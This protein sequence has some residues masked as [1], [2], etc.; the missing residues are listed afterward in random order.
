VI[1]VS[2][3]KVQWNLIRFV[4]L[5]RNRKEKSRILS[6]D[7][8]LLFLLNLFPIRFDHHCPWLSN[9]VGWKNHKYFIG[10]LFGL[11]VMCIL[12][13]MG[14]ISFWQ[15]S[16]L[17]SESSRNLFRIITCNPWVTFMTVQAMIHGVWVFCLL[18]CQLYQVRQYLL[19]LLWLVIIANEL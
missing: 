5:N 7:D 15:A 12:Y 16:C 6:I 1:D 11:V 3:S 18:T 14:A 17:G 10:Y 2:Q 9:C 13:V 19:L 4:V 8:N